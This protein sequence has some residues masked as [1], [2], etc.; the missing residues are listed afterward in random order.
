VPTLVVGRYQNTIQEI[1]S[2]F[3][4]ENNISVVRR[5]SGGGAV[6]QDLNCL[7]FSFIT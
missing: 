6:Y 2:N 3:V 5:N 7:Q 1:N 4:K